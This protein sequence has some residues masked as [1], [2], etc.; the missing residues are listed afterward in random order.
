MRAN[1]TELAEYAQSIHDNSGALL[2]MLR[3]HPE[4]EKELPAFH[5]V[6]LTAADVAVNDALET[7]VCKLNPIKCPN[8][9][10]RHGYGTT[11]CECGMDISDDD[12]TEG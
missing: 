3:E 11:Y 2:K 12:S 9:C 8:C 4:L 5:Y 7:A 1:I 10:K 6:N